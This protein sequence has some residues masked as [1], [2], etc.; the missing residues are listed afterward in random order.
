VIWR[1][2]I[3]NT[4]DSDKNNHGTTFSMPVSVPHHLSQKFCA[5]YAW[6]FHCRQNI[7]FLIPLLF[8]CC[9]HSFMKQHWYP[10]KFCKQSQMLCSV[11]F[12]DVDIT[13]TI[14][15]QWSYHFHC[16][17]RTLNACWLIHL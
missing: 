15:P 13:V 12:C 9:I 14:L 4:G 2:T 16:R 17:N 10:S 11:E 3:P 5:S 6:A 7:T 8:I 1:D